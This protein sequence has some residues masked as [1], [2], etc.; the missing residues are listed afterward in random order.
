[1]ADTI[2]EC[3]YKWSVIEPAIHDTY[4]IYESTEAVITGNARLARSLMTS[5]SIMAELLIAKES[6]YVRIFG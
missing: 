2:K 5:L 3:D 4:C 6:L 1:M